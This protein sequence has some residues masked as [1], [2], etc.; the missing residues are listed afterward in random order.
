MQLYHVSEC[1]FPVDPSWDDR[2]FYQYRNDDIDV[3][4]VRRPRERDLQTFV[5]AQIASFRLGMSRYKLHAS[6]KSDR[7]T[8]GAI[9]LRH[10][11]ETAAGPRYDAF[12]FFDLFDRTCAFVASGPADRAEVTEH[13]FERF[14]KTFRPRELAKP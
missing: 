11:Y 12:A 3:V 2:S 4:V 13:V 5:D 7:P 8:P 9:L 14:L 1:S 10:Q 6:T